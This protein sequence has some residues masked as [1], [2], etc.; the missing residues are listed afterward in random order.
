MANEDSDIAMEDNVEDR[1]AA[2]EK[3]QLLLGDDDH[4]VIQALYNDLGSNASRFFEVF[5]SAKYIAAIT[6]QF[7]IG[8]PVLAVRSQ[9]TRFIAQQLDVGS[10][11]QDESVEVF[12]S[13]IFPSL[14]ATSSRPCL[15]RV[16][17][18]ALDSEG[19]FG[20]HELTSSTA[21]KKAVEQAKSADASSKEQGISL[22]LVLANAVA[23]KSLSLYRRHLA[24]NHQHHSLLPR[25]F[26]I[27]R[28]LSLAVSKA[29]CRPLVSW[30]ILFSAGCLRVSLA[31]KRPT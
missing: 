20:K 30:P 15:S 31:P 11:T 2:I 26:L 23:G 5:T 1:D 27:T 22:N 8:K 21:F 28:L 3:I 9:H 4:T 7:D 13:T 14:L 29:R 24:D 16:E 17:W 10:L 12:M 19:F 6:P 18:T 25:P